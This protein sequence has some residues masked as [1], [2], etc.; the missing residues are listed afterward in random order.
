MMKGR[1]PQSTLGRIGAR[2]SGVLGG[3]DLSVTI[4]TFLAADVLMITRY[5]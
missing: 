2:A 5:R 1:S 3:P 4:P